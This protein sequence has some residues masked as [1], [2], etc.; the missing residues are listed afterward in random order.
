[1][2]LDRRT[3]CRLPR[4]TIE[5][6]SGTGRPARTA[7]PIAADA[8]VALI[9]SGALAPYRP[10]ADL[11][12]TTLAVTAGTRTIAVVLSGHGND[13][14]TGASAVHRFGGTF[15][16]TSLQTS[17]QPS[18]PQA[19]I[20]RDNVTGH[21]LVLDDVTGLLMALLTT[22]PI[23]PAKQQC[24]T[25]QPQRCILRTTLL[26]RRRSPGRRTRRPASGA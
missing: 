5:T 13:A 15:I 19:T 18:M 12:L 16:A 7:H 2:I 17:T 22:P 20:G 21:V 10:S 23:A 24:Q 9:P 11:P 6:P 25:S 4:R 3:A 26:S 1:V 8:T 14:A